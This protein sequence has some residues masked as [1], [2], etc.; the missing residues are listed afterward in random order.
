MQFE[1][2]TDRSR[3]VDHKNANRLDNRRSNLRLVTLSTQMR[4]RKVERE[5]LSGYRGITTHGLKFDVAFV[6]N[7]MKYRAYFYDL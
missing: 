2:K 7:K 4:N 1:P 5:P 3:T 6:Y